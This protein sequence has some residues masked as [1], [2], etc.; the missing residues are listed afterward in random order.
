MNKTWKVVLAFTAVFL[1]GSIFGGLL[2]MRVGPRVMAQKKSGP[3]PVAG[4]LLLRHFADRLELTPEQKEKIR[5][6]VERADEEVRRLRQGSLKETGVVLRRL[7]QEIAGELTAEQRKK[8]EKLQE[9][10]REQLSRDDRPGVQLFRERM[11]GKRDGSVS[12]PPPPP[13]EPAKP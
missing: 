11:G 7:Q 2:A 10:Q 4:Q 8:L 12:P 1:A 9:R 3:P 5:P 13:G 6:M